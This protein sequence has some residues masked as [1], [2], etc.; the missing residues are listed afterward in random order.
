MRTMCWPKAKI[1]L[2]KGNVE[3]SKIVSSSGQSNG[4]ELENCGLYFL[5]CV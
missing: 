4:L 2:P 5:P 3:I 1:K